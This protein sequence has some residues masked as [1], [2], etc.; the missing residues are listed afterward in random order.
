MCIVATIMVLMVGDHAKAM[1]AGLNHVFQV[2]KGNETVAHQW[3]GPVE[4]SEQNIMDH[5]QKPAI[6]RPSNLCQAK[7]EGC[8]QQHGN[9]CILII[10]SLI[11]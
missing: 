9:D 4:Q 7:R 2:L 5:D 8:Y 11:M 3:T 6:K 1:S 10:V